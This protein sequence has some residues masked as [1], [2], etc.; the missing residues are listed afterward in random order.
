MR[1]I[2]NEKLNIRNDD[3]LK[4]ILNKLGIYEENRND[5]E[6]IKRIAERFSNLPYELSK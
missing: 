4:S 2:Q 6:E 3:E 1:I 5:K